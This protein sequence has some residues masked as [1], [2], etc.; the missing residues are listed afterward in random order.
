MNEKPESA[1]RDLAG[2]GTTLVVRNKSFHLYD[3]SRALAR[4]ELLLRFA[5]TELPLQLPENGCDQL[6][7]KFVFVLLQRAVD[8]CGDAL[9]I[10]LRRGNFGVAR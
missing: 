9:L 4:E 5:E 6:G 3:S 8:G 10:E 2:K 1:Q 7:A